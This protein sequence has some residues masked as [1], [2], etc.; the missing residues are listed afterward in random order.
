M[1]TLYTGAICP[2]PEYLHTPL[3]EI[4][5]VDDDTELKAAAA[6]LQSYD[7]LLFTSRFAVKYWA[8][9][10]GGFHV[11]KIVS[12]G[13]KTTEALNN[14]GVD[15]VLQTAK[16]DSY[17]V[18]EWFSTQKRGRVLVPRSGIALPIIPSGLAE[19]GFDVDTVVAYLNKM[20]KN[21][22]KVNLDDVDTIIF[23]SPSTVENFVKIYGK[24]PTGKALR[25][26][27]VVTQKKLEEKINCTIRKIK[28]E[29]IPLLD[30][31]LYEAI[32]LPEVV[33]APP[34]DIIYKPE[35][36]V[37]VEDF[38][39]RKGDYCL[40]ADVENK[41]VGAV[42]VRIMNDYGHI[43]DLTPSLAISLYPQYRNQGLGTHL[44]REML[45]LLKNE[46]YKQVSLSVQKANYAYRMYKK[47]GF[48]IV[49]ENDE[50]YLMV[51]TL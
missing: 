10:G 36:Q 38:G 34:K 32:F 50:E 23:T 51:C 7:Y 25:S 6:R 17:G 37:Y 29:E 28:N 35:L 44:M 8:A 13:E 5:P 18:L 21:P 27:G 26:R 16:D 3:I 1:K 12:I 33:V 39:K 14:L 49:K 24:I 9:A 11:D 20:P 42:W 40:V 30:D 31:F 45:Q 19:L 4:V 48:E 15:N 22:I 47:L 2:N 41:I 46:N 43:D